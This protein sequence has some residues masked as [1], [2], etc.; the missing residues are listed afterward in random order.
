MAVKKKTTKNAEVVAGG[1]NKKKVAK[2]AVTKKA[3]TKKK[4]AKKAVTS[5]KKNKLSKAVTPTKK[6]KL[7]KAVTPAKK[8]KLNRAVTPAKKNKLNRAVTKKKVAKKTSTGTKLANVAKRVVRSPVGK[9]G[10]PGALATAAYFGY[11]EFA[12]KKPKKK[13]APKKVKVIE[14]NKPTGGGSIGRTSM[15]DFKPKTKTV[16]AKKKVS[17]KRFDPRKANRAGQKFGQR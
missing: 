4:V 17:N 14:K 10:I 3:V 6:N 16:T 1:R 2:K 11:K 7:S 15:K 12:G 5:A 13:A 9:L 8:N